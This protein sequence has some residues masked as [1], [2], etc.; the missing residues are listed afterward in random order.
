M[1]ASGIP[2]RNGHNHVKEICD[3]ALKIRSAVADFTLPHNASERLQMR[4]GMHTGPVAAGVVGLSMPHYCLF[5]EAVIVANIMEQNALP[6][7]ILMSI[8]ANELLNVKFSGYRTEESDREVMVKVGGVGGGA[9]HLNESGKEF[10]VCEN[11]NR[12]LRASP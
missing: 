8:K 4:I 12:L 9:L 1:V 10:A 11:L 5:G 3:I 6:Q 2:I 7:T